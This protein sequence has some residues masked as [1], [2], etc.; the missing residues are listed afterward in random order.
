MTVHDTGP[1]LDPQGVDRLFEAFYTTKRSLLRVYVPRSRLGRVGVALPRRRPRTSVGSVRVIPSRESIRDVPR[2][3]LETISARG[4]Y[5]FSNKGIRQ[6]RKSPFPE[7]TPI[8]AYSQ[9]HS[10]LRFSLY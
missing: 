6:I 2:R 8:G 7:L 5:D 4:T 10:F 9:A 1:G 3:G